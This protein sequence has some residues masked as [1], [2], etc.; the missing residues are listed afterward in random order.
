MG[1]V[2]GIEGPYQSIILSWPLVLQIL[3]C[4][5]WFENTRGG[6]PLLTKMSGLS[7]P[8]YHRK[9]LRETVAWTRP[10][11]NVRKESGMLDI[12]PEEFDP[13]CIAFPSMCRD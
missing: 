10:S 9:D 12:L 5:L 8:R 6:Q 11:V 2:Y 7:T 4:N 3:K 13:A 1:R